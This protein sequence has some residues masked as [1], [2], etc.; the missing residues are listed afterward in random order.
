VFVKGRV[1]LIVGPTGSGKSSLLNALL[2]EMHYAP[3][4]PSSWLNIPTKGGISYC[5]QGAMQW[6]STYYLLT[7]L[8]SACRTVDSG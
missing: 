3:S 8:F 4:G 7:R 1:N 6:N 2:G 5:A